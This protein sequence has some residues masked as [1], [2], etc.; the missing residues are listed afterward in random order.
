[1]A[2]L[3]HTDACGGRAAEARVHTPRA[4]LAR[5]QKISPHGTWGTMRR[6]MLSCIRIPWGRSA[7]G[8][9]DVLQLGR[10]RQVQDIGLVGARRRRARVQLLQLE[11]L[12]ED[13]HA[14]GRR[15]RAAVAT[16]L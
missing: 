1:M 10:R 16:L 13:G 5:M 3:V 12:R 4:Q 15:L 2:W 7:A 9:H 8:K 11:V 14:G 6:S